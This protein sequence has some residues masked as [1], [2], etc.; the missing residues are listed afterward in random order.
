MHA[1]HRRRTWQSGMFTSMCQLCR[2]QVTGVA[3]SLAQALAQATAV[4]EEPALSELHHPCRRRSPNPDC[5]HV[6][7]PLASAPVLQHVPVVLQQKAQY[8]CKSGLRVSCIRT[9]GSAASWPAS[10]PDRGGEDG[11]GPGMKTDR[12]MFWVQFL[13]LKCSAPPD[14][15]PTE[16]SGTARH[17][18][19]S[20]YSQPV[21]NCLATSVQGFYTECC[22]KFK[23]NLSESCPIG[24]CL[25]FG[26][27]VFLHNGRIGVCQP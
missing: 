22:A 13:A 14:T 12:S 6:N 11:A 10:W 9:Y 24:F 8:A 16:Y 3:L 19:A 27:S 5:A 25:F 4:G 18:E 23:Q 20:I 7:G 1:R 2:S 21:N 17:L 15:K 26:L